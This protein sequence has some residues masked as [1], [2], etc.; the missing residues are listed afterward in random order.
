MDDLT[1]RQKQT[2]TFITEF[3]GSNDCPPTLQEIASKLG[4]TGNLGVL[5]HLRALEGKGYRRLT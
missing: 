1:D 4:I 3:I 2:L 5:R